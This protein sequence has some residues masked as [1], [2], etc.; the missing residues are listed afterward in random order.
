M[1][2]ILFYLCGIYNGGTEYE[3]LNLMKNLN[4]E[5]Y[6]LLYYYG[7]KQYSNDEMIKEYNKYAKYIDINNGIEVTTVIY[8]TNALNDI[9]LLP[10]ISYKHSYYWFHY[11]WE[12]QEEF[13][14]LTLKS[15]YIDKVITVSEYAKKRLQALD[16]LRNRE[17]DVE[18]IHN[19]LDKDE[20]LEKA[21]QKVTL[22]RVD[23]LN[24]VTVARFAPI[25]GYYRVK[26]MINILIEEGINF[27]WYICRKREQ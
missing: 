11:F 6:E 25:K 15:N 3:T 2:R 17:N 9:E 4:K 27:K 12:D 14:A 26:Q 19:I 5:K 10:K 22:E 24:L 13:L 21:Q 1:K 16:C 8:C 7:D 20:I 23:G 18:I